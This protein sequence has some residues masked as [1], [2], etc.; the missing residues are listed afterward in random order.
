MARPKYEPR[1]YL[2]DNGRKIFLSLVRHIGDAG[3]DSRID[4]YELTMLANS[5]DLYEE[6]A[7]RVK[8]LRNGGETKEAFGSSGRLSTDY[9]VM[10][11]E[12]EKILKHGPK[13]GLNPGD[14]HK[15]FGGMNKRKK[16]DPNDGLD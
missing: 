16:A 14:R 8:V 3:L 6:A 9:Q 7:E 10:A 5:F 12:Y 15:I 1:G 13:Y 2:T 11:K 4:V